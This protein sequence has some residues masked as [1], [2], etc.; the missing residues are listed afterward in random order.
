MPMFPI[1][2]FEQVFIYLSFKICK[3]AIYL[4]I[5]CTYDLLVTRSASQLTTFWKDSKIIL[6]HQEQGAQQ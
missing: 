2:R 6:P 3:F 5:V 4:V 1:F